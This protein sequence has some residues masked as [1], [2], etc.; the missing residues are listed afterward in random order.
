MHQF[1]RLVFKGTRKAAKLTRKLAKKSA[2]IKKACKNV[3]RIK[4]LRARRKKVV[5]KKK[6]F[7]VKTRQWKDYEPMPATRPEYR[8]QEIR[9]KSSAQ[10][11]SGSELPA[12]AH[13]R[14]DTNRHALDGVAGPSN[15]QD[16]TLT[17]R[18]P[19][20][21]IVGKGIK[22]V[23]DPDWFE[24]DEHKSEASTPRLE[25][26]DEED[27][28]EE[29][30]APPPRISDES[31]YSS[32]RGASND[33]AGPSAN[34]A[35]STQL[36]LPDVGGLMDGAQMNTPYLGMSTQLIIPGNLGAKVTEATPR[37]VPFRGA[38]SAKARAGV[39]A[40]LAQPGGSSMEADETATS[41]ELE[42]LE[43]TQGA[44]PKVIRWLVDAQASGMPDPNEHADSNEDAESDKQVEPST[45]T[46]ST[47]NPQ[48]SGTLPP[49]RAPTPPYE[50]LYFDPPPE[51][52]EAHFT[53][54]GQEAQFDYERQGYW[55]PAPRRLDPQA[56]E[57]CLDPDRKV[58]IREPIST[59][60]K[61]DRK[62]R[63][64]E[65][66]VITGIR[67]SLGNDALDERGETVA[68]ENEKKDVLKISWLRRFF[69][70]WKALIR[71]K[72][73]K[74]ERLDDSFPPVEGLE[75]ELEQQ[76][77]QG[78]NQPNQTHPHSKSAAP[79]SIAPHGSRRRAGRL[80]G[81]DG[82]R[83]AETAAR[84]Q[85]RRIDDES[86]VHDEEGADVDVPPLYEDRE[87]FERRMELSE[88]GS[89]AD[90]G[91]NAEEGS[92]SKGTNPDPGQHLDEGPT[93][94]EGSSANESSPSNDTN[95][96]SSQH[97][98]RPANGHVGGT[99]SELIIEP[100]I[101]PSNGSANIPTAGLSR[102][103]PTAIPSH[104]PQPTHQQTSILVSFTTTNSPVPEITIRRNITVSH[105]RRT[106]SFTNSSRIRIMGGVGQATGEPSGVDQGSG[107][108]CGDWESYM[109][110]RGK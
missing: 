84:G 42:T 71:P 92:P 65:E 46:P 45:S 53:R 2:K 30:E 27:E 15:L 5:A 22:T 32:P 108:Y 12:M 21:K 55:N 35:S 69:N 68:R 94:D 23:E 64:D 4:R 17:P 102:T 43:S 89:N 80:T 47:P 13:T 18:E 70:K 49:P 39:G 93:A 28:G 76:S 88:R 74:G 97:L 67:V 96:E 44:N 75:A 104:Q 81:S 63:R 37:D 107:D 56:R 31:E 78:P 11:V 48:P 52:L 77:E 73:K 90:G 86:Q 36:T 91:S 58:Q 1:K 60:E 100:T 25:T 9:G 99:V 98:E 106:E 24:K 20:Q 109:S 61:E 26:I 19:N 54:L 59:R 62:V 38:L 51:T 3:L 57:V 29:E 6:V 34:P 101:G 14:A 110:A 83:H 8:N 72:G 87:S 7:D 85:G 40:R 79:A 95:Q 66:N 33:T 10:S 82:L 50:T 41:N 103:I 16:T 105:S